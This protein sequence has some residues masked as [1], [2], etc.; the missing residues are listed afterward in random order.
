M[1]EVVD[2]LPDEFQTLVTS[3]E[4]DAAVKVLCHAAQSFQPSVE[5]WL[6]LGTGRY[7]Y[8]YAA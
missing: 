6:K 7:H 5:T 2:I 8:L 4:L 1:V 3:M